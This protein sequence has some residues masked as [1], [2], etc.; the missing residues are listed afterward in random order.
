MIWCPVRGPSCSSARIAARTSP[1]PAFGPR[2][3]AGGPGHRRPNGPPKPP[4]QWPAPS[5][6]PKVPAQASLLCLRPCP[7]L[8]PLP[9][10]P[11]ILA[12]TSWTW[13]SSSLTLP[14]T[15]N[16]WGSKSPALQLAPGISRSALFSRYDHD[17]SLAYEQPHL[18]TRYNSIGFG[19]PAA[20]RR[21]RRRRCWPRIETLSCLR[22][23]PLPRWHPQ[24]LPVR[25]GGSLGPGAGIQLGQDVRHVHAGRLGGNE[26]LDTDL[27]VA[28]P[29]SQQL[30]DL[31]LPAGQP[32]QRTAPARGQPARGQPGRLDGVLR[33]L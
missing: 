5:A 14:T 21:H 18:K 11:D 6:R 31:K 1:R 8:W 16:R 15:S 17:I 12:T 24:A 27:P 22:R 33:C 23:A 9:W 10:P 28:V 19:G 29:G 7:A 2:A 3:G 4:G 25:D 13:P 30:Q 26:E 32:R 20:D